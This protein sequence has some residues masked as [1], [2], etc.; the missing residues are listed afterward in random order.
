MHL[1]P[2]ENLPEPN[3]QGNLI[4]YSIGPIIVIDSPAF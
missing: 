4:L 1:V 3:S 2:R